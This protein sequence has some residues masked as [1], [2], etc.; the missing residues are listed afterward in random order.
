VSSLSVTGPGRGRQ[1]P[2]CCFLTE[3]DVRG[4]L[5]AAVH[6]CSWGGVVCCWNWFEAGHVLAEL[7]DEVR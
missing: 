5:A 2:A 3:E 1:I 4:L 6:E 7:G